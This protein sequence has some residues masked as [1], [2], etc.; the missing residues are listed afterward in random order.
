MLTYRVQ[1]YLGVVIELLSA[2]NVYYDSDHNIIL[3]MRKIIF[4]TNG[5][6]RKQPSPF[7]ACRLLKK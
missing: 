4:G 5:D 7:I 3:I 6:H 2:I 1:N